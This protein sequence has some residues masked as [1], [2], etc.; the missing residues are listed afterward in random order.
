MKWRLGNGNSLKI[1]NRPWLSS[2]D[3]PCITFPQISS[4]ENL[5]LSDLIDHGKCEWKRD[6]IQSLFDAEIS[7]KILQLPLLNIDMED[8]LIQSYNTNGFCNAKIAYHV[9]MSNIIDN[10]HLK[11]LGN[12]MAIQKLNSPPKLSTFYGNFLEATYQQGKEF[13]IRHPLFNK[14][15][16]L[17]QRFKG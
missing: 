17:L 3:N 12:W 14:P 7:N 8:K 15:S 5:F 4:M 9:I 11:V 2:L 13:Y 10:E 6:R 16:L 1:L